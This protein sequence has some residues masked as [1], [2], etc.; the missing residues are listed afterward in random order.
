[1]KSIYLESSVI[2]YYTA[3][4]PT[5]NLHI[6]SKMI[7][8]KEF[9]KYAVKK[10]KIYIS[11]AVEFEILNGDSDA[12]RERIKSIEQFIKLEFTQD[13][14]RLAEAYMKILKLPHKARLDAVHM[15]I[16]SLNKIDYLVTW[17]CTHIAN[18]QI[19]K[20]LIQYNLEHKIHIPVIC[21]PEGLMEEVKERNV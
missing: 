1:M 21:T 9:W 18:G 5:N 15:A 19:M 8:T 20:K 2:S 17:N 16:S 13:H 12:S 4:L 6:I 3:K 11:E 14:E 10:Y 7:R